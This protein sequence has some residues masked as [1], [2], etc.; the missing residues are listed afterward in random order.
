[1]RSAESRCLKTSLVGCAAG[2]AGGCAMVQFTRLW[3]MFFWKRRALPYSAQEWDATSRI[4]ESA[5]EQVLHRELSKREKKAG[6][7]IAHYGNAAML[8]SLYCA[9]V[10][11]NPRK[12]YWS[13]PLFGLAVGLIGNELLMPALGLN[14]KPRQYTTK[15]RINAACEHLVYGFTVQWV[16]SKLSCSS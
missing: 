3:N 9:L 11:A 12:G 5:A 6:A 8:G 10:P 1:M 2:I 13:G 7:A 14:K 4:A 15:M 16:C